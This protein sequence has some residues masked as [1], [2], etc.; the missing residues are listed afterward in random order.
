M[1]VWTLWSERRRIGGGGRQEKTTEA[2]WATKAHEATKE[3][4][5]GERKR[6]SR[7][8]WGGVWGVEFDIWLLVL[9]SFGSTN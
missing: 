4:E 5:R 1:I 2:I 7:V 6:W 8:K 3:R 9:V